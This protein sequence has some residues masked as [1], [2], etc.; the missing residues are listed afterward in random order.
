MKMKKKDL[1]LPPANGR[2]GFLVEGVCRY[3][4]EEKADP[5][6]E[7]SV[8]Y[9]RVMASIT[10]EIN[11]LMA[12]GL[13][14][15]NWKREPTKEIKE[16]LMNIE[17]LNDKGKKKLAWYSDLLVEEDKYKIKQ[18]GPDAGGAA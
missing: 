13:W 17:Q 16:L 5:G 3:L 11:Q 15:P 10:G 12:E 1:I 6:P 2:L 4:G 14:A 8:V 7:V 18:D 9:G